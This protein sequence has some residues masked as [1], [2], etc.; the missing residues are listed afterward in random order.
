VITNARFLDAKHES[1]GVERPAAS[2]KLGRR[3]WVG[4][5]NS[6]TD[7][8]AVQCGQTEWSL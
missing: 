4:L 3:V 2:E 7:K 8:P 5:L 1:A 6:P